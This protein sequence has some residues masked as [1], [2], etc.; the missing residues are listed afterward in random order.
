MW[1]RPNEYVALNEA[2][3]GTWTGTYRYIHQPRLT[4][5]GG[6]VAVI[7]ND[8]LSHKSLSLNLTIII[9]RKCK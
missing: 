3:P 1:I 4:G 9:S 6:R 8:N 7:Y 2:S 5:R